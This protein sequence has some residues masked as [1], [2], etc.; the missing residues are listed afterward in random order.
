MATTITTS[1]THIEGFETLSVNLDTDS[2]GNIIP[3]EGYTSFEEQVQAILT[4]TTTLKSADGRTHAS[5]PSPAKDGEQLT[6]G[7]LVTHAAEA[8]KHFPAH[9]GQTPY[10]SPHVSALRKTVDYTVEFDRAFNMLHEL[11]PSASARDDH[12]ADFLSSGFGFRVKDLIENAVEDGW[13]TN[14]LLQAGVPLIMLETAARI[15]AIDSYYP[16]LPACD[17]SLGLADGV[18]PASF[19]DDESLFSDAVQ[20]I[21]ENSFDEAKG[22]PVAAN[23]D[24]DARNA[25]KKAKR[26][27]AKK[28]AKKSRKR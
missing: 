25:A 15:D 6:L 27:A 3:G 8:V 13:G 24:I 7:E 20:E 1:S 11:D 4:G 22:I 9:N 19:R 23:R 12:A 26:K 16:D 2:N 17:W 10:G 21:L 5:A 14:T 28:A 18:G